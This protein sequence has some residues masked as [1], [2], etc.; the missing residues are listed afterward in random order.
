MHWTMG[1]IVERFEARKAKL[2]KRTPDKRRQV[3]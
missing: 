2:M 1:D 3:A